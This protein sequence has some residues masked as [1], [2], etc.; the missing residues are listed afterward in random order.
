M[1]NFW[2]LLKGEVYR[3]FKYK[4]IY[5][6]FLVSAIWVLILGFADHDT[7]KALVPTL[8]IMDAGMMSVILLAASF[9][10]EKQEGTVKSLLVSPIS[11]HQLLWAKIGAMI[12]SGLISMVLVGGAALIFHQI[13]VSIPLILGVVVLIVAANVVIGYVI[14]LAAKDFISMLVRYMGVVLLFYTPILLVELNV[15]EGI[16][17]TISILSPVYAGQVLIDALYN[18]SGEPIHVVFASLYLIV[19]T[20]SIYPYVYRRYQKVAIGG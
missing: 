10:Y 13:T 19:L 18:Q 4:I 12:V 1:A 14:T 15:L 5:F 11:V 16:F 9:Y 20:V 8:M 17:E 2:H 7:A 3:L 6:G